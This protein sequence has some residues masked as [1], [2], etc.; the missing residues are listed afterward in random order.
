MAR[1]SKW[2]LLIGF[3]TVVVAAFAFTWISRAPDTTAAD[4][5]RQ[6]LARGEYAAAEQRARQELATLTRNGTDA[7]VPAGEVLD[8]LVTALYRGGKA[9][10]D[11][12]MT[13]AEQAIEIK[14]KRLGADDPA[15]ATSLDNAGVLCFLRGDYVR[16]RRLLRARAEYL[17][18]GRRARAR[19]RSGSGQGAL[20]SGS[21]L[22]GTRTVFGGAR[23]LRACAGSLRQ[24]HRAR[25]ILKWR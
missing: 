9:S 7:S 2:I 4:E 15:L 24:G 14:E 25:A 1:Q 11:E 8:V 16:A 22:S 13:F 5:L 6:L 19:I 21:A 20:S 10:H 17:G 23:A 12:A 18:D 3:T